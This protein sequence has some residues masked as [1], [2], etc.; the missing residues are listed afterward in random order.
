LKKRIDVRVIDPVYSRETL[1]SIAEGERLLEALIGSGLFVN[2]ECGGLGTCGK[3]AIQV[4]EGII[5]ITSKD[6]ETFS[7]SELNKG[8]RLACMACPD[9]DCSIIL[10]SM[11]N[12]EYKVVTEALN[13]VNLKE[14]SG[15]VTVSYSA[16]NENKTSAI[17]IDLG[18]TTLALALVALPEGSIQ[19]IYTAVNPQRV[20]G[21]DVISRI[22]ASNEGNKKHLSRLIR[23]ELLKGIQNLIGK[24]HVQIKNMKKIII[25][26]NT[27]MIHLLMEYSC[28]GL[29]TY[30]FKPINLGLINTYTDD[31]FGM[32]DRIPVMILPGI[33]VYVGGDITAGLLATGMYTNKKPCLLIDLG[34]N[35]EMA[36]G[37]KEGLIVSSTAA[38]P[39]FEGSNISCGVASIPGAICHVTLEDGALRYKTIDNKAPVGLCGTGVIEL[40]AELLKAGVIDSSGLLADPYFEE[41]YPIA[42]MKLKQQ[43][44]RELQ[45]AKAAIRAGMDTLLKSCNISYEELDEVYIAGAFGYYLDIDKAIRTDLLPEALK[46]KVRMVGNTS[47]S[48]AIYAL[49]DSEAMEKIEHIISSSK[50][51]HLSNTDEFR[52]LFIKYISFTERHE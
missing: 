16:T 19:D 1:V 21:A 36:L 31:I 46:D 34:T 28:E 7:P 35:G 47:L 6:R 9:M 3:C 2:S 43:D 48:G 39:A 40:V 17:V 30:P 22:K 23:E 20:Y 5:N 12:T 8:Y 37:N 29:G 32:D 41:G 52:D 42:G 14:S 24:N 27:T 33:S 18:T 11:M 51:I 49:T 4:V 50:E 15:T 13:Q 25:S 44:I 10:P 26:A 38:G 45:L